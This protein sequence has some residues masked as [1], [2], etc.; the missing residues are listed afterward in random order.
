MWFLF[1]TLASAFWGIT[2]ALNEQTYKHISFLSSLV[3]SSAICTAVF[4]I[5]ALMNGTLQKDMP[6]LASNGTAL[7]LAIA[8]ALAL[9][10]A[11]VFIGLSISGKNATLAGL[12]EISYPIF[13]VLF[14]FLLFKESHLNVGTV[15]GGIG[16]FLGIC[17]IYL[18]NR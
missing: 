7:T 12:I 8:G 18:F 2:Y 14:S 13:I 11:E 9:V 1:A 16:I 6:T 17:C 4:L 3:I 10:I 5:A 15:V